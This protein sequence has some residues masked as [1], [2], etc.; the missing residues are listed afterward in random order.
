MN[1]ECGMTLHIFVEYAEK[2][3]TKS[4]ITNS[5]LK[6]KVAKGLLKQKKC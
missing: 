3:L 4:R 5:C 6:V 1:A 2:M